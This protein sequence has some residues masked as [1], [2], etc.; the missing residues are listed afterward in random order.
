MPQLRYQ[1]NLYPSYE[2]RRTDNTGRVITAINSAPQAQQV[3]TITINS[4]GTEGDVRSIVIDG[5]TISYTVPNTPTTT[6]NA[7]LLAAAINAEPLV[8]G[9]ISAESAVAVVTLTARNPGI[10]WTVQSVAASMTLANV[11][12]SALA[13]SVPFGRLLVSGGQSATQQSVAGQLLGKLAKASYFTAQVDT[14]DL[15]YDAGILWTVS[16]TVEGQ[17]YAATVTQ[18]TDADASVALMVTALNLVLP[19]NT[20]VASG[21]A[22]P[23]VLTS[24]VAGQ[25]FESSWSFGTGADTA[26]IT[27]T[28]TASAST[29]VNRAALGVSMATDSVERTDPSGPGVIDGGAAQYPPNYHMNVN[30][31]RT[32]VLLENTGASIGQRVYVRL[33]ADGSNTTLAGFRSTPDTGCVLLKGARIHKLYGEGNLASIEYYEPGLS[34]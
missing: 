4:A 17:T 2:G 7:T 18:A 10:G 34:A 1:R 32:D 6:N 22:T 24:E 31:G 25:G 9:R 20:V 8:S 26:A 5:V 33:V 21:A 23:L 29:D 3:D 19:A 28:S 27:K 14:L 11:T 16:I 15:T 12:S 30:Q 13:E